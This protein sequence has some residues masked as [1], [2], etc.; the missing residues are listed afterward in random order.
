M[1][2]KCVRLKH[3]EGPNIGLINSLSTFARINEYGFIESPYRRMDKENNRL[4]DE[5]EYMTA[6]VEDEFIIAQANEPIDEEEQVYKQANYCQ[7]FR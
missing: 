1:E 6:D 5:I 7:I 3:P 4:T 2:G